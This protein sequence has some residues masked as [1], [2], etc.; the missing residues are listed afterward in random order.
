M[1]I[2]VINIKHLGDVIVSTAG[3]PALRKFKPDAEIVF[4]LREG[5]EQILDNNPNVNKIITFD[6][7]MKGNSSLKHFLNGIKFIKKIKD[8]KFDVVIALHP[9][10]RIAF[11]SWFSGAKI[12]IAPKH[13]NFSYLFNSR[14]DIKENTIAF[15]KYYLN[16][17]EA[18][19]GK[20]NS[21]KTEFY[22]P[23]ENEK[24]ADNFLAGNNA[25][26]KIML[27]GFHPAAGKMK[28]IWPGKNFAELINRFQ[29]NDNIKVL[30]I[31]G[32]QDKKV[33]EEIVSYLDKNSVIWFRSTDLNKTAALIKRCRLF[34]T[35]DTGTRHLA[36][37]LNTPVLALMPE[38]IMN[39]W[40]FYG[41]ENLHYSLIGKSYIPPQNSSENAFL[42]GISVEEVYNKITGILKL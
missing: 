21:A 10:D 16:L 11:W 18:F 4:L 36:V 6:P 40:G 26:E 3:L 27:I 35:H 24:W 23:I 1:K 30:I 5:Y 2:L 15:D 12:R 9:G 42:D 14:V 8:E 34:I 20:I 41:K 28:R 22:I 32:P 7:Q 13:Q 25:V 33:I 17:F 39:S 38:H 29:K 31:E 37:A 19:T